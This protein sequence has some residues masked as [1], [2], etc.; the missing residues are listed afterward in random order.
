M[1]TFKQSLRAMKWEASSVER[2]L[3]SF[4]MPY[5]NAPHA[6]ANETPAKLFYGRNLRTRLDALK[7]DLRRDMAAKQM[8]QAVRPTGQHRELTV[9]QSVAVQNYR[10]NENWVYGTVVSCTGPVSYMVETASG[11]IRRRHI[12]QKTTPR[13]HRSCLCR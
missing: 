3:A 2:K 9:G 6:T 12:E 4:V 10:G 8:S 13:S 1:Q 11:V 5:R 7:P